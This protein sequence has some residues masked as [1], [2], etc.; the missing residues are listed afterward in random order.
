MTPT[1]FKL[2]RE[3]ADLTQSQL[4]RVL[5]LSDSRTIRRY[6][7]GSRTVSGPVAIILEMMDAGELP[8]RFRR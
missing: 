3:R 6:E 4:A 1:E 8:E 7:D 5:R 2:I